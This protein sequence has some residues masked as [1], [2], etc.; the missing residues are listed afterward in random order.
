MSFSE[1]S[2]ARPCLDHLTK[3][4]SKGLKFRGSGTKSFTVEF[5]LDAGSPPQGTIIEGYI[6]FEVS[7][8]VGSGTVRWEA[9]PTVYHPK[10]GGGGFAPLKPNMNESDFTYEWP[11]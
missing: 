11:K 8:P 5:T 2:S 1:M 7:S 6:D 3:M 9:Q 10:H 4:K